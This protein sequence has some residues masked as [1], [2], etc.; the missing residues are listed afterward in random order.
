MPG[1]NCQS[2]APLKWRPDAG[3]AHT[4]QL[5]GRCHHLAPALSTGRHIRSTRDA[6]SRRP[7]RLLFALSVRKRSPFSPLPAT[8]IE[9]SPLRSASRLA[10]GPSS[11]LLCRRCAAAP[12]DPLDIAPRRRQAGAPNPG[13][14]QQPARPHVLR[15]VRLPLP[16]PTPHQP[17][18]SG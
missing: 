17:V 8:V 2:L 16:R 12:Q 5:L 6:C 11:S 13:A 14:S 1:P 4:R 7:V 18:N 3:V 9:R 15:I 10:S